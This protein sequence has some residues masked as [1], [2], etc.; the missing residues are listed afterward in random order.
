MASGAALAGR[1]VPGTGLALRDL[2]VWLVGMALVLQVTAILAV[3][4]LARPR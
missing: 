2:P 3:A 1:R 4:R